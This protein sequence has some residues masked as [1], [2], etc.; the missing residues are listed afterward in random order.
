MGFLWCEF[1]YSCRCAFRVSL[2]TCGAWG[3]VC[4]C[5]FR[6]PVLC[7]HTHTLKR[8]FLWQDLSANRR[9]TS[10]SEQEGGFPLPVLE[11]VWEEDG[12]Y[13][14]LWIGQ[15]FPTGQRRQEWLDW[16]MQLFFFSSERRALQEGMGG[17][18]NSRKTRKLISTNHQQRQNAQGEKK[19]KN[20]KR[21][22]ALRSSVFTLSILSFSASFTVVFISD[23]DG[24]PSMTHRSLKCCEPGFAGGGGGGG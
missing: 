1:S 17:W 13:H 21:Q 22:V 3:W 10:C 19:K 12:C 7:T 16:G 2:H 5:A 15:Q 24:N 4:R 20:V 8:V 9:L 14:D 23:T 6:A 11:C 18:Q